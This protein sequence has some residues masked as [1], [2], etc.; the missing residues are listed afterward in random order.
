MAWPHMGLCHKYDREEGSGMGY[1]VPFTIADVADLLS[2]RRLEGGTEDVFGVECPFCGDTRGKCNFCIM[3]DGEVK[4]VYHCY[5]C[6]AAGNMLTLYVELTG[7]YGANRYKDAYWQIKEK[8]DT[9]DRRIRI[10]RQ[11]RVERVQKKEAAYEEPRVDAVHLDTVYREMLSMLKLKER[12][13]ADLRRRGLMEGEIASMVELGYRSTDFT[14][15]QGIARKLLARGISL[16]GVPGFYI[17]RQGDW[18]AAFY[19]SNEGYLCPVRTVDGR[20]IGFQ[21]RLDRPYKK[22]KYIWFTSSG[23]NGGTSSKSPASLSGK[24][25]GGVIRVTEGILKA[26]IACQ[27]SGQAYI[28]NPGVSNYKG[29][30]QILSELKAQ[31]LQTV[32]ECYDMDKMMR[33]DCERDYDEACRECE[34]RKEAY[35]GFECPKKRQKRDSIRKGCMKLYEICRE[36]NLQ[37][38]RM[39]WDA[40]HDGMWNGDYKGIDDW[41]LRD[42]AKRMQEAA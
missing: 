36:L 42:T 39:T 4:N 14:D 29:V 5:A 34:W 25:T 41:I 22:R 18:E 21:I 40:G 7:L 30:Y 23:L 16:K 20:T 2:I 19:P 26:E 31:G 1:E 32:L 12:H 3:R 17:N 35:S 13:K 33:L 10:C 6:G 11:R 38:R 27:C 28:G 24:V 37:C 9:G 15:S 8:L